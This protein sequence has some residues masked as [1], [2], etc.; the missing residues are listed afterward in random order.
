MKRSGGRPG[1]VLGRGQV[2][3]EAYSTLADAVRGLEKNGF[4]QAARFS[5]WRGFAVAVLALVGSFGLFGALLPVGVPGLWAW[6][7]AGS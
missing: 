5:P 7:R 4:A 2:L 1:L 6:A 3:H